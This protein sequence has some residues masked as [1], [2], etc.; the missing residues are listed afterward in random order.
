MMMIRN[1]HLFVTMEWTTSVSLIGRSEWKEVI[2]VKTTALWV[3][4]VMMK[5]KN[6]F[7]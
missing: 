5:L 1:L 2:V 3:L 4:Y 7:L 6:I